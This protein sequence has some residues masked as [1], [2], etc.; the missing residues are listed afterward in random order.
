M[1]LQRIRIIVGDTGFEPEPDLCPRSLMRYQTATT[2]PNEPPHLLNWATTSPKMTHHSESL[3]FFDLVLCR[4]WP[5]T[6]TCSTCW[7]TT[8]TS[9]TTASPVS[10]SS[11]GE[12]PSRR[13]KTAAVVEEAVAVFVPVA[14]AS[15][16]GLRVKKNPQPPGGVVPPGANPTLWEE[17]R[18][19]N[20]WGNAF[21]T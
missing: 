17:G 5:P 20:L 13:F 11:S 8:A 3:L 21:I 4:T 6:P 9:C 18:I 7:R 12:E 14:A 1:I 2:S 15:A 10:N 19:Q 16:V